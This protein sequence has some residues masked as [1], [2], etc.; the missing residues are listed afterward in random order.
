[1]CSV[2]FLNFAFT[3]LRIWEPVAC[4]RPS[5]VHHG[6]KTKNPLGNEKWIC[7]RPHSISFL[8]SSSGHRNNGRR[9][10]MHFYMML[11]FVLEMLFL[12]CR[13]KLFISLCQTHTDYV[14]CY[15]AKSQNVDLG[16]NLN[17]QFIVFSIQHSQP[18]RRC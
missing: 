4:V 5:A 7:S 10:Y 2:G 17:V 16:L 1:M 6:S 14:H 9:L 3:A 8:T 18:I 13:R 12:Q 15:L 11:L